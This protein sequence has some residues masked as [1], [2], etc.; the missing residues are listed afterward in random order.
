MMNGVIR[1]T[2]AVVI[3]L[4]IGWWCLGQV[5]HGEAM[6][7]WS[8]AA[9]G[10]A[11]AVLESAATPATV[12][13]MQEL[14][15]L[16]QRKLLPARYDLAEETLLGA[17]ERDPLRSSLW[18]E[19]ARA[20]LFQRDPRGARHCL[21]RADE[22][23]PF[24]PRQRAEAI[25]LWALLEEPE[26]AV[27]VARG[28]ARFGGEFRIDAA[29]AL[30]RSTVAAPAEVFELVG[31]AEAPADEAAALV[32]ALKTNDLN[33]MQALAALIPEAMLANEGFRSASAPVFAEPLV[34]GISEALWEAAG[35]GPF[36][37]AAGGQ[38]LLE[39][40]E[41]AQP[42]FAIPFYYGWQAH[43]P[44]A[45]DV[46]WV[47]D[48]PGS[49][50]GGHLLLGLRSSSGKTVTWPFYRLI[51]TQTQG[52]MEFTARVKGAF[53]SPVS[54]RLIAQRAG[55]K[56]VHGEEVTLD[57]ADWQAVRVV[58]PGRRR[59]APVLLMLQAK[60]ANPREPESILLGGI[61]VKESVIAH[62]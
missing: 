47:R 29:K 24:F 60:P 37:L 55:E 38:V 42:P 17:L 54:C 22:L 46:S 4:A 49:D 5:R 45:F 25:Q 58:L 26:E 31:G 15:R 14:A 30:L 36:E 40:K 62:E 33:R 1:S 2:I 19:L 39:N 27:R 56:A 13:Q 7:S 43:P 41:I 28:L 57:S 59:A 51:L 3:C 9:R 11:A 18:I 12:N 61:N 10:G 20:R 50:P 53:P 23:D 8:R 16:Q 34:E 35:T 21:S 52:D 6:A 44:G 48:S 32:K